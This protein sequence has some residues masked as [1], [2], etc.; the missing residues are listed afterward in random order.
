M[1]IFFIIGIT[2]YIIGVWGSGIIQDFA[3][4]Q[5]ERQE[6]IEEVLK[7]NKNE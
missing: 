5:K 3:S 2:L 6:R 1:K 7:E 4:M